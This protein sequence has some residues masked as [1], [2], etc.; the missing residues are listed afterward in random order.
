M[1]VYDQW[2]RSPREGDQPCGCGTKRRPLYPG[3][4]HEVGDRWQ[5][6]YRDPEGRQRKRSFARRVGQNPGEHAD[7]FDA[8]VSRD[9]DA[10]NYTDPKLAE[11]TFGAYAEQW[12]KGRGYDTERAAGVERRLRLHAYE[13]PARPGSGRTPKGGVS[14]GQ[15][16]LG[17]LARR[18]SLT[19]GWIQAMPLANSSKRLVV[20]DVSAVCRAAMDDG[21][22]GRDPTRADSVSRPPQA[23]TKARPWPARHVG[24]MRDALP[25]RYAIIPELGA[26]T[27]M[28]QGELFGLGAGDVKFLH[29]QPR[30]DVVRQVKIVAG[31]LRF[32]PLKNRK[33]HSVPLS[34]LLAERLAA[35]L[36]A[37]PAAEVTLPWHDPRDKELHGTPVTVR[38]VLATPAGGALSRPDFNDQVWRPALVAAGIVPPRERGRKRVSAPQ[39]GCHALRH[40]FASTQLRAGADVVRVA[41]WMGDTPAVVYAT[42]AHMLPGDDD[43]DARAATD[44]F[45]ASCAPDVPREGDAGTSAQVSGASRQN[46]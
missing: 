26:G 23:P 33:P 41:A 8:Q 18:P 20:G 22:I 30:V 2:H 1:A 45:L 3:S 36:A 24:A 37:Y 19:Q 46:R 14:I 7:A 16:P 43:T 11:T 5:V 12:R 17:L 6:R 13:D 4:R 25:P 38:L 21:I 39:D 29:R 27:G 28:R 42:Y 32:A 40:T 44:A 31:Q 34:P 9:V 15:H 35:H 10:G